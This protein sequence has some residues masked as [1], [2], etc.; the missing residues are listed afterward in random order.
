MGYIEG[1]EG[2]F[3]FDRLGRYMCSRWRSPVD[4]GVRLG[5][6]VIVDVEVGVRVDVAVDVGVCVGSDVGV[7]VRVEVAVE[8]GVG[9]DVAVEVGVLVG[10]GLL[11]KVSQTSCRKGI[12][13]AVA[14][15]WQKSLG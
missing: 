6:A 3:Y 5:V 8:I 1:S 7:G 10:M 15:W 14:C 11:I 2:D 13:V 12:K 4:T 9:V